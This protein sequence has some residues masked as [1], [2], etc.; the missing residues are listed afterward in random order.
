MIG[1]WASRQRSAEAGLRQPVHWR[2]RAVA[3]QGHAILDELFEGQRT[4][5]LT[6][7]VTGVDGMLTTA[8]DL[9]FYVEVT[10]LG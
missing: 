6:F 5:S 2:Y 9:A 3:I 4:I 10:Q 7:I 1:W 8:D